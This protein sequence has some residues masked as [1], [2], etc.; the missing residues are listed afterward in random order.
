M[1]PFNRKVGKEGWR[2]GGRV[3]LRENLEIGAIGPI[4]GNLA[5]A[6]VDSWSCSL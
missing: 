2:R 5:N 6:T 4:G 1:R 3:C